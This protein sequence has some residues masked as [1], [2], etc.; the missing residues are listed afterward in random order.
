[1]KIRWKLLLLLLLASV[2]PM[3]MVR[4]IDAVST[5]RLGWGLA[6]QSREQLVD[7]AEDEL[8]QTLESYAQILDRE[9]R[10]A[11]L[12]LEVQR[13]AVATRFTLPVP[14]RRPKV[15]FEAD[16]SDPARQPPDIVES[17]FHAARR[18]DGTYR[19][20]RVSF[21]HSV[22]YLPAG[23]ERDRVADDIA[24]LSTMTPVYQ[25]VRRSFPEGIIWQYTALESGVHVSYPG[26]G[27]YPADYD[28][29]RRDWYRAAMQQ[30]DLS[31]TIPEIDVT[32]G[33]ALMTLAVRINDDTG[34]TIG[35]TAI[36]VPV[37]EIIGLARLPTPWAH[38]AD[39]M[40]VSLTGAATARKLGI[41]LDSDE[42]VP[43]ITAHTTHDA[44]GLDWRSRARVDLLDT[45]SNPALLQQI[46]NDLRDRKSAVRRA[47]VDGREMVWAYRP[48]GQGESV[49]LFIRVPYDAIVAQ[50]D[51][52]QQELRRH[53]ID[54]VR[55]S[56]VYVAVVLAMVGL[57]TWLGSRIVTRP[58]TE[59]ADAATRIAGGDLDARVEIGR[60]KDELHQLAKLF[61]DMVPRLKDQM[62]MRQSLALAME[63]QQALL[64]DAAPHV[65]GFD[66]A[67]QSV[68]CDE[69]GGDYYDYFTP[70]R[71][72]PQTYAVVI[73][74]VVGHGVAAA[75]LMATIR[76]LILSRAAHAHG[77]LDSAVGNVNDL[78]CDAQ[79][80]GRF[81]TA[82]FMSIYTDRRSMAW[83][84]AGHDP[85]IT[86]DP[87]TGT[88]G[89]LAGEDIPLGLERQWQFHQF[90]RTGWPDGE[91]IVLG[92]DGIWECRNQTDEM[93]GK[94]RLRGLIRDHADRTA[95]QIAEAIQQAVRDYRGTRDQQDDIT[96]VVIKAVAE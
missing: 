33:R 46:T 82:F 56:A 27:D 49:F 83:V 52:L 91:I 77:T 57:V 43:L 22:V 64:P 73:G 29:R 74:D 80:T 41:V 8:R 23:I 35:V 5:L 63:V 26:K 28:P 60:G 19:P 87:A 59:M 31:W 2:L 53:T 38:S 12:A 25:S 51:A 81:M 11:E 3:V 58:V 75:L 96:L 37:S 84:S 90:Q 72:G 18:P 47:T 61:N 69:T 42:P 15:Y 1:M 68:Y 45:G 89:E 50:A 13:K 93:F 44:Q 7:A 55:S 94:D 10:M 78:L 54:A 17:V 71:V 86:Y 70:R 16:F 92:T 6:E 40:V 24:R 39:I 32:T 21:E 14:D 9:G 95:D 20:Q 30:T 79:F 36:D 65:P 62:E 67:G 66:I 34:R 76:G 48:I 88:F 4:L 85:A